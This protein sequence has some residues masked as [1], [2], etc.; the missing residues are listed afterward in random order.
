MGNG[1]DAKLPRS[2]T[3]TYVP[4]GVRRFNQI[5]ARARTVSGYCSI[6]HGRAF[7]LRV[8]PVRSALPHIANTPFEFPLP[9]DSELSPTERALTG[10]KYSCLHLLYQVQ[11]LLLSTA[12]CSQK[13]SI[14]YNMTILMERRNSECLQV[15]LGHHHGS[16]G[17][18]SFALQMATYSIGE[19]PPIY[20]KHGVPK[21]VDDSPR[22]IAHSSMT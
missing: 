7:L 14:R 13:E 20:M 11:V 8:L 22:A 12:S 15:L 21:Q 10:R 6:Q 3:P 18:I 2:F 5:S 9:A 1:V 19:V 17:A 16:R 4:F